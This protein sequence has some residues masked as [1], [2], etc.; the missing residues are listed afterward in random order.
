MR[1]FFPIFGILL[2]LPLPFPALADGT[3]ATCSPEKAGNR[4]LSWLE[5]LSQ[6]L[7]ANVQKT[8]PKPL[9]SEAP[10]PAKP[11][12]VLPSP[13]VTVETEPNDRATKRYDLGEP[14]LSIL[15]N[16]S[17]KE[18]AKCRTN[19]ATGRSLCGIH[20]S[21]Y[22]CYR[23]VK[24]ALVDAGLVDSWW[25]EVAASDAHDKGTLEKKG[26]KNVME[27]GYTSATAPLGAVLVYSGGKYRCSENGRKK[28]CGHIEIKVNQ[29]EYCSDYCKS[30]PVDHYIARKLVGIYVKE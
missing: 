6:A 4:D 14:T 20:V 8:V 26:F 22:R 3:S 13:V 21:K 23:G 24:D 15:R 16:A 11:N 7:N 18:A 1:F 29:N 2:T 28:T 12:P 5:D 25:P 27:E 17:H 9:A 19:L 30:I 10:T